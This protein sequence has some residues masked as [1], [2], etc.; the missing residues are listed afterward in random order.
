MV[1]HTRGKLIETPE[2]VAPMPEA[3]VI[4]DETNG[5]ASVCTTK[6]N[7]VRVFSKAEHGQG[8]KALAEGY[9]GKIGGEVR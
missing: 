9:A 6:G 1:K 7:L 4:V 3:P 2:P 8:Y 5:F